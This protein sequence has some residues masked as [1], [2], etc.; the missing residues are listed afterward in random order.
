MTVQASIN[1]PTLN[2]TAAV[3]KGRTS[4][5]IE[6]RQ[7]LSLAGGKFRIGQYTKDGRKR[8]TEK[9]Q[10]SLT[11]D[12]NRMFFFVQQTKQHNVSVRFA[13]Q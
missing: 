10:Y 11:S 1:G 7:F 3:V 12:R 9:V 2:P 8:C 4:R 5:E 13:S 6:P